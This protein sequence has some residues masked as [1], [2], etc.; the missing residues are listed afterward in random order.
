M[1]KN[2]IVFQNQK[3]AIPN[4]I[5]LNKVLKENKF[6]LKYFKENNI[7][8]T[9]YDF[10]LNENIHL[11]NLLLKY[12]KNELGSIDLDNEFDDIELFKE[13][14]LNIICF[15][16]YYLP[17]DYDIHKYFE[18]FKFEILGGKNV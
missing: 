15:G 14:V 16:S 13:C 18:H 10:E 11:I 9:H 1:N 4:K 7:K 5:I 2:W 3:I 12:S 17:L 6:Q 8:N